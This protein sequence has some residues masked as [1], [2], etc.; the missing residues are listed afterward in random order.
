MA[1]VPIQGPCM[2]FKLFTR[3]DKRNY[4]ALQHCGHVANIQLLVHVIEFCI[5]HEDV[6]SCS[7][8]YNLFIYSSLASQFISTIYLLYTC[9]K[10]SYKELSFTFLYFRLSGMR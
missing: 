4:H 1:E 7:S 8:F 2:V 6:V 10:I 5:L 3:A 9:V